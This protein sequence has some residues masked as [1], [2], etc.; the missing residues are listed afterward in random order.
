[1]TLALDEPGTHEAALREVIE[2]L[3]AHARPAGS[4]EER[5]A[6][7]W[8]ATRL[9]ASG[10]SVTVDAVSYR[11]GYAHLLAEL[12]ALGTV[13]AALALSGRRRTGGVLAALAGLLVADDISNGPRFARRRLS[14][15]RTTWNVVADVGDRDA[16]RTL[17]VLAHHDSARTGRVFDQ[18]GSRSF[19]ER[20]PEY[21]ERTDT[22]F[23]LWWPVLGAHGL[24][25]SGA[26]LRSRVLGLAGLGLTALAT[27]SFSDIARSPFVAG[28]NDNLSGVAVLAAV[29]D[30]LSRRPLT[31]LRVQLV[32]CGAEEVCQGGV[33]P[34]VRDRLRAL[35]P[36][37]TWVLNLDA[38]ASPGLVM[39]EGEGP[40]VMEDYCEPG[41]RDLVAGAAERAGVPLRRGMRARAST[42]SVIPS[43]AGYPTAGLAS[44]DQHKLISNYHQLS[45]VPEN[46]DY[47]T[48]AQAATLTEALARELAEKSS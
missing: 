24:V 47:S 38:V 23:P 30:T 7:E 28:A 33:I 3:G 31:G 18:R 37:R 44:L 26:L 6:A 17:V 20:F 42:D 39:L 21:V 12:C 48:V 1:V 16:D 27:A 46:V 15:E 35:D 14:P 36:R 9:R 29:A 32:S 34:Y 4:E 22:A 43:R 40:V 45:D 10:A 11:E 19:A 8:L 13:G 41:F 5:E 2:R 25:V